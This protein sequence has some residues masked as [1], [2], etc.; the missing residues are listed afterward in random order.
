MLLS[1]CGPREDAQ[2]GRISQERPHASSIDDGEFSGF[3][4][5]TPSSQWWRVVSRATSE[6]SRASL[7]CNQKVWSSEEI[8]A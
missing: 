7:A 8:V 1:A 6:D 2:L 4:E 3:D 5:D